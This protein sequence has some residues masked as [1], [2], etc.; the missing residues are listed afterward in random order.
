MKIRLKVV[1][2]RA[3]E[4]NQAPSQSYTGRT[5]DVPSF[6]FCML[7]YDF[8][9]ITKMGVEILATDEEYP[10][11]VPPLPQQ[12]TLLAE[13]VRQRCTLILASSSKHRQQL[14]HDIG[15]PATTHAVP[16]DEESVRRWFTDLHP[17]GGAAE[18]S[19]LLAHIKADATVA[20]IHQ[21]QIE[22]RVSSSPEGDK[23][24]PEVPSHLKALVACD[25]LVE[26]MGEIRAK[27]KNSE[28]AKRFLC[29]YS[30]A[31]DS[32][33]ECFSGCVVANLTKEMRSP[34]KDPRKRLLTEGTDKCEA[35][36]MLAERSK[37]FPSA[38][39]CT[40]EVVHAALV[41][42]EGLTHYRRQSRKSFVYRSDVFFHPF[43]E[44]EAE[45][46]IKSDAAYCNGCVMVDAGL[47]G[48]HV[49]L[50][51]GCPQNVIGIPLQGLETALHE[52]LNNN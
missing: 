4:L 21:Q 52:L 10:S 30:A 47:S 19:L 3:R 16:V 39:R 25:S 12:Y 14:L 38:C 28:E 35:C 45:A 1:P 6:L 24:P 51:R 49:K 13:T 34:P 33:V 15:V 37:C 20:S 50:I 9:R 43:S 5:S 36:R 27:P 46:V 11:Y 42:R 26:F 18:L 48:S 40:P 23:T 7:L 22:S 17:N 31:P 32:P 41:Y 2:A 44:A 29:D 8:K